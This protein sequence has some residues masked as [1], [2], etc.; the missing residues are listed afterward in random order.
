MLCWPN[1]PLRACATPMIRHHVWTNGLSRR[2]C[3]AIPARP[4]SATTTHSRRDVKYCTVS[5]GGHERGWVRPSSRLLPT[6]ER[7]QSSLL[8]AEDPFKHGSVRE[9]L[10]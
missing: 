6:T 2:R 3:S 5:V 1:G 4:G 7:L 9:D 10:L 8:R